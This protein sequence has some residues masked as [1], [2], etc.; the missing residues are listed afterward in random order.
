VSKSGRDLRISKCNDQAAV[1]KDGSASE[2]EPTQRYLPHIAIKRDAP[3]RHCSIDKE[4]SSAEESE[5]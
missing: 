4:C 3:C 1:T 5:Q 2:P